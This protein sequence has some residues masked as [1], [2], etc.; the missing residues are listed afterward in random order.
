MYPYLLLLFHL[1]HT[2]D[3]PFLFKY[4]EDFQKQAATALCKL[5]ADNKD[6][7][8]IYF[9]QRYRPCRHDFLFLKLFFDTI[10]CCNDK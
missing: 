5:N 3:F 10:S 8:K 9:S 4:V 1:V 2:R 7:L 6:L